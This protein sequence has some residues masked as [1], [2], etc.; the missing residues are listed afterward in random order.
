MKIKG[1]ALT[2]YAMYMALPEVVIISG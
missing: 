2:G 1:G